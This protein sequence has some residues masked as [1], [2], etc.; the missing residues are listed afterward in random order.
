MAKVVSTTHADFALHTLGWK[1]FQD[2]CAC[3]AQEVLSRPV[4]IYAEAKDG[5]Q[6]AVFYTADKTTTIQCKFSSDTKGLVPSDLSSEDQ[7]VKKLVA[8]GLADT[9]VVMTSKTVLGPNVVKIKDNL[10]KLGVR[11]PHV[12]G[13]QFITLAIQ[14]NAKLRALIPRVYGLGDLSTI[15][16]ERAA[17]QT[18]SLLGHLS[19]TLISYVPTKP[20]NRAVESLAE[21]NL[22]LLLGNAGTGKSTIAAILGTLAA[23]LKDGEFNCYKIDNP[24]ELLNNWNPNETGCFFWI[25]DAFGP[26]QLREDYVDSWI[27]LIPKIQAAIKQGNTFVLTSR[28]HI[29]FAA[30]KKLGTRNHPSFRDESAI[31]DV[32]ATTRVE[33]RQMLYNHVK[34]GDQSQAWKA[35]VRPSLE[36]ISKV[37]DFVPEIAR[38]LG[39][40]NFTKSLSLNL[41]GL[42]KFFSE[43]EEHI[44]EVINELSDVHRAALALV[45][46]HSGKM[47]IGS[48]EQKSVDLIQKY[49]DIS[50]VQ[51][52]EAISHHY[53][54]FLLKVDT[55]EGEIVTF[56]HP[57]ISDAIS[58]NFER[59][60]GLAELYLNSAKLESILQ[61]V[62]CKGM[63]PFKDAMIIPP[64]LDDVLVRRI[65]S[66]ERTPRIHTLLNKFMARQ[67]S[68][69]VFIKIT[70]AIPNLF[71]TLPPLSNP[72]KADLIMETW[73]K[74]LR[75]NLLSYLQREMMSKQ[76]E[77]EIFDYF[78]LSIFEQPKLL[79]LVLPETLLT[80][81]DTI[82]DELF[83]K[84]ENAIFER[85]EDEDLDLDADIE[86]HFKDIFDASECLEHLFSDDETTSK[87]KT[88]DGYLSDAENEIMEKKEAAD[89]QAYAE[90]MAAEEWREH[91]SGSGGYARTESAPRSYDAPRSLF[92]DVDK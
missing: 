5:G 56:K 48:P 13:K 51:I 2:L 43:P 16:D 32:G 52:F 87:I 1:A 76:I 29:Y 26:N 41:T 71:D 77:L 14:R 21:N 74:A 55:D 64:D 8:K 47:N 88:L 49:F 27:Q 89:L 24:N 67:V 79:A 23:S 11:K 28:R 42:K 72:L 44:N 19:S 85:T 62:A 31:V 12:F 7:T 78:D 65:L 92:S 80:L 90:D 33:R 70:E 20:H 38:R 25:D 18:K 58:K 50:S 54:S 39:N 91:R 4:E 46:L 35:R 40:S 61:L 73:A 66:T 17:T 68:K 81:K 63:N 34:Y 30:K 3:I 10:R 15:L 69:D 36:E 83:E 75:F 37:T 6:D 59:S 86:D 57:S 22:V 82:R 9:Y 45:H 60:P 84:L 53:D